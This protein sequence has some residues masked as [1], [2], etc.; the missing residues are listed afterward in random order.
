MQLRRGFAF[1][2]CAV[3]VAASCTSFAPSDEVAAETI[4]GSPGAPPT[5]GPDAGGRPGNPADA[6]AAG[7]AFCDD[8]E[9]EGLRGNWEYAAVQTVGAASLALVSTTSIGGTRSLMGV[10]EAGAFS[11]S[12]LRHTFESPP[13][14][15]SQIT[16]ALRVEE[17]PAKEVRILSVVFDDGATAFVS[18]K[19]PGLHVGMSSVLVA[20]S[21]SGSNPAEPPPLN[22]W[23]R[24]VFTFD[25]SDARLERVGGER[26]AA[27]VP[28]AVPPGIAQHV[29]FGLW[30]VE[31]PTGGAVRVWLDEVAMPK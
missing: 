21:A 10:A 18:L 7:A 30:A 29:G 25:A 9:R 8:F 1:G 12:Y 26:S 23:A 17:F 24:Y 28:F 13:P 2:A 14:M 11:R 19:A 6:C 31:A 15:A 3:A 20:G 22:T 27:T 4:D 5:N 16:F